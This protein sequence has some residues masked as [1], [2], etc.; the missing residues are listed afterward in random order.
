MLGFAL[1]RIGSGH[2]NEDEC[3]AFCPWRHFYL[4]ET[5]LVN[6]T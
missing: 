4:E 2:P 1:L 5:D 6:D 3:G